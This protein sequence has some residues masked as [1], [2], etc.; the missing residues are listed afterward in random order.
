MAEWHRRVADAEGNGVDASARALSTTPSPAGTP[1]GRNPAVA[2]ETPTIL[3]WSASSS[4][5]R[6]LIPLPVAGWSVDTVG[7]QPDHA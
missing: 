5:N 2:S 6:I 7:C 3:R 1:I 4:A